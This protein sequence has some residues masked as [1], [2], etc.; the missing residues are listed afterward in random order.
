MKRFAPIL[1]VL[2]GLWMPLPASAQT[3]V[4]ELRPGDAVEIVVW[5]QPELSGEFAIAADSSIL[6]PLY[7]QV[8]VV[9]V[10]FYEAEARVRTFLQ[11]FEADP[12]FVMK[13][14]LRVAVGGEVRQPSLYTFAPEVT[15]SQAVALA[16]GP[17]ERG[18]LDRVRLVRD[19]RIT[20]ID[21]TNP[22]EARARGS[23]RSGDQLLLERQTRVFRDYVVPIASVTGTLLTLAHL[24]LRI[25]GSI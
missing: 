6:H 21:L 25:Q 20:V 1:A 3:T 12:Q 8:K 17:T 9:G 4:P 22:D 16:G 11:R 7:R 13:P 19:G 5:R 23:V 18:R 14:L 2:C 24:V 15:L 10:P